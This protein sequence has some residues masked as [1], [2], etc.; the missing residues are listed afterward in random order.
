M[1]AAS[2]SRALPRHTPPG[3][4]ITEAPPTIPPAFVST[5][6]AERYLL[7]ADT[8]RRRQLRSALLHGAA[9][10]WRER[11]RIWPAVIAGVVLVAV[12]LAALAVADAFE[13]QQRID[14]ERRRPVVT[15]TR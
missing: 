5:P 6:H 15:T 9:Q 7:E 8:L 2:G 13:K 14:E 4:A 3:G 10:G 11:Q 12:I 1:I